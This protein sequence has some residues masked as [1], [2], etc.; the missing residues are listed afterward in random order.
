MKP[1]ISIIIATLNSGKTLKQTL[2][3]IRHQTYK[4]IELIIIDGLSSDNTLDL[5]KEYSDVVTKCIS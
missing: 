3:S 4:N 5:I 2:D 1:K